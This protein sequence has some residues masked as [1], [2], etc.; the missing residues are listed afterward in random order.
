MNLAN[1]KTITALVAGILLSAGAVGIYAHAGSADVQPMHSENRT[2]ITG[3]PQQ[4]AQRAR[5]LGEHICGN[6][7]ALTDCPV[8]AAADA[9]FNEL[10]GMQDDYQRGQERLHEALTSANFDSNA[11]T[12]IQTAQALAIQ[13]SA[14]RYMQFLADASTALTAEQRQMFSRKRHGER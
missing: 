3:T 13:T 11:F 7:K 1:N 10:S 12:R 8:T 6:I 4:L 2:S 14:T 5:D 9:A